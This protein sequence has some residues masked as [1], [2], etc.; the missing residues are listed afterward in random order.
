MGGSR[1]RRR[2]G[3]ALVFESRHTMREAARHSDDPRKVVHLILKVA[4]ARLPRLRYIVDPNE[5]GIPESPL[6]AGSITS[7]GEVS[8]F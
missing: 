8:D 4:R 5:R 2:C 3:D 7:S 1:H 6:S